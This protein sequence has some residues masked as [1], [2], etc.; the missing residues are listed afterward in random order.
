[1]SGQGTGN[2]ALA[3]PVAQFLAHLRDERQLSAHTVK[4]YARDLAE[5][6]AYL[7]AQPDGKP[8]AD[9]RGVTTASLRDFIAKGHRKGRSGPSLGRQLSAIRSL[10]RYLLREGLASANP[11]L[12][13]SAPKSA[14]RLPGA[15]DAD[16]L[17]RLLELRADTWHGVRDRAM[18]ELFY[19]SGLR[20]AELVGANLADLR[21]EDATLTVR[22]KGG[23]ERALPVGAK[24]LQALKA[25]LAQRAAPPGKARALDPEALFL[26][27]S[28]RRISPRSVQLRVR[29]WCRKAGLGTAVHPHALRHSF[30]SHLLESSQDLRAVQELLGHADIRTTQVY[31]HL[32]FQHLA[33]VYDQAHPRAQRV[34][35]SGE[36]P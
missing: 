29:Q 20:L 4:G 36:A 13:F 9:W 2:Q 23:K 12:A 11:A 17:A 27:E 14:S 25:W 16:Q 31:A 19:S 1:M 8:V 18:L 24:A 3:A 6:L 33:R 28:G 5:L 10:Y 22:G 30:A 7:E 35:P 26:S 21:W 34:K 15:L 32:D